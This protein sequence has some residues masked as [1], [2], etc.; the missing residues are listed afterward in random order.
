MTRKALWLAALVVVASN[1]AALGFAWRNRSGEPDAT[2]NL[3][4]RELRLVDRGSENTAIALGVTWVDPA[5]APGAAGWLDREGLARLGFDVSL[6]VSTEQAGHYRSQPPRAAYVALEVDGDGWRSYLAS[7]PEGP[8]REEALR[9]SHL[10]PVD[11]GLDRAALRARH[12][13]RRRVLVTRGS[14]GL[15]FRQDAGRPPTLTGRL[16][17]IYPAE[18]SVPGPL[19]GPLEALAPA[20]RPRFE[21]RQAWRG[22]PLPADPRF[23]ATVTWGRSL[24]PWLAAVDRMPTK[25]S[26]KNP[27]VRPDR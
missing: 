2:V 19:R 15:V 11:A 22:W 17:V 6:P 12:P 16:N 23:S 4:E 8:E 25:L 21:P 1:A 13:D 5:N 18:L 20:P 26:E 9:G 10:V 24:E 7:I 3:T 27:F 14:I